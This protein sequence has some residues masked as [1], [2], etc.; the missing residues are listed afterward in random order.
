[1]PAGKDRHVAD[2]GVYESSGD[3]DGIGQ[4]VARSRRVLHP[5]HDD[6]GRIDRQ[7][8][9]ADQLEQV[10]VGGQLH[11][12]VAPG[13]RPDRLE[14]ERNRDGPG[15]VPIRILLRPADVDDGDAAGGAAG[16]VR[17]ADGDPADGA[18]SALAAV[19]VGGRR[20]QQSLQPFSGDDRVDSAGHVVTSLQSVCCSTA[21]NSA[22]YFSNLRSPTPPTSSS[23]SKVAGFRAAISRNVESWKMT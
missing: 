3:S 12:V 16:G 9:I 14:P 22:P 13:F 7:P 19:P 15:D 11:K 10:L 23:S 6:H 20:P 21:R 2:P 5:T 17:P 1:M 4:R 8:G 18:E